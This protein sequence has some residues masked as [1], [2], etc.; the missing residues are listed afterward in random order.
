M[1]P[2]RHSTQ[3]NEGIGMVHYRRNIAP[4]ATYF[5]T[6]ALQDRRSDALVEH[7]GLLRE[8]WGVANERM[9]HEVIAA[10]VLPDHLHAVLALPSGDADYSRLW[11]EIK[12]GFTRRMLRSGIE[13][14]RRNNGEFRLWQRRF[15][16][17]TIRDDRDLE[18]HVAYVHFNSVKHGY[19]RRVRD[20]P[21]STF[22]RYVRMGLLPEDWADRESLKAVRYSDLE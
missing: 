17:H 21:H 22:H 2:G 8:A 12:K 20:W 10:A 4:G 6:L 16:E 5:F 14:P 13:I 19:A 15:W 18:A 9:P 3:D 7:I 11:Q 1:H